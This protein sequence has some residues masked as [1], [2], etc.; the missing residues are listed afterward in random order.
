MTS[1][2]DIGRDDVIVGN[3]YSAESP[4]SGIAWGP[5]IG[6][7]SAAAAVSLILL[8]L[9]SALGLSSLSPWSPSESMTSLTA[10]TIIWLIVMQWIASG[11]GGYMTGRLRTKWVNIHGEEVFFRDTAHG[12]L[13]WA[14]AT[15]LTAS[16][17][18]S[19]VATAI[20]GG[21][22]ASATVAAGAAAGEASQSSGRSDANSENPLGYYV[23][24]LFRTTTP[25]ATA[26]T[27][28]VAAET[29]RIL[30]KDL[31]DGSVPD[32]DKTYLTQ[33]VSARTGLSETDASQRVNQVIADVTAAKEKAK[34][35]AEEA[36]KIAMHASL[37]LFLS[38][39]I[40]A[41]IA[42]SA[43]AIGGRH[44]DEYSA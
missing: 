43:A 3:A 34:Q 11:F 12:F 39:L 1:I 23:D 26:S 41:F 24:S 28:D 17:L 15:L 5:I 33:L 35:K 4:R 14:V 30:V 36:R 38:L 9:G 40:G 32:A 27:Q 21:V 13:A 44:R 7:A 42:S 19:A 10:K 16:V 31:K 25:N 18:T 37:Y 8:V 20:G 6:G 29:T 22:Q 2:T